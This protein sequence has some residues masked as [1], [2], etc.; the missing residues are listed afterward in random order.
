MIRFLV[1]NCL[2][3]SIAMNAMDNYFHRSSVLN[4]DFAVVVVSIV[5][6]LYIRLLFHAIL[7]VVDSSSSSEYRKI[8]LIT[9]R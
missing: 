6:F 9:D 4:F 1:E 2:N 8:G 5:S 7:T 3:V